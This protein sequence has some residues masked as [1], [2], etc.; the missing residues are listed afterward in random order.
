MVTVWVPVL[1]PLHPVEVAVITL[2]PLYP[3]KKVT[4]PELEFMVFPALRLVASKAKL[5]PVE[6]VEVAE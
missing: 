6:F 2:I 1:G 4:A 5:N 3:A